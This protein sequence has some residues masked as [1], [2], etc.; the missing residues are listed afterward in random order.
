MIKLCKF[1]ELFFC[2]PSH[3]V[4]DVKTIKSRQ[5][6]I[7]T[8]NARLTPLVVEGTKSEEIDVVSGVPQGTV[9][10]PLL[11]LTYI[12]DLPDNLNSNTHVR[13]FADDCILY[14]VIDSAEDSKL[15]QEDLDRLAAWEKKWGMDFHPQKCNT[16]T[17]ASKKK[18]IQLYDYILKKH[19]L[20]RTSCA[21]YLGVDISSD[22]NWKNHIARTTTKANNMLGFIRRNIKTN[23][24]TIKANAYFTLVRPHLEYCR[25]VAQFGTHIIENR[26]TN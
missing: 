3:G 13:L 22:L 11:F 17:S 8:P 12:N 21:K 7:C 6:N 9:L 1:L 23:N 15:L 10:G 20:A 5:A 25:L 16:M 4:L 19:T 24:R 2:E 14:R 26:S 18:K